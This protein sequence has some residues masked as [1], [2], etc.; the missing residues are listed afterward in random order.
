MRGDL[1]SI[2]RSGI[3]AEVHFSLG[4][5][6]IESVASRARR[7]FPM[8]EHQPEGLVPLVGTSSS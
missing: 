8:P 7:C 3:A 5:S 1:T 4:T 2:R 6:D